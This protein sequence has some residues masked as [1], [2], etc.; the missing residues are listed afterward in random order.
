[1]SLAEY[2]DMLEPWLI[3]TGATDLTKETFTTAEGLDVV[4]FEGLSGGDAFTWL[5]YVSDGV[6][7]EVV[8]WFHIDQ[9]ETERELA[10]HSFDTLVVY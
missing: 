6:G 4:L 2:A 10:Y 1:M 5:A 3:E 7:V 9:F 8:Y